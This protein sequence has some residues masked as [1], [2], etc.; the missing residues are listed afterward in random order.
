MSDPIG[1]VS[2][3]ASGIQW[4]DLVD[5]IVKLETTRRIDPLTARQ[6][7][8]TTTVSAWSSYQ[9]LV[10][11]LR[12]AASKIATQSALGAARASVGTSTAGRTLVSAQA[13][14]TA[15]PGAYTIQVD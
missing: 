7:A 13:T 5:Q 9:S 3:L 4:R 10:T 2:G 6:K 15:T 8:D 14:S 12:D 11:T 1:S